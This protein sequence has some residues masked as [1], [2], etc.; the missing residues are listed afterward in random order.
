MDTSPVIE[1]LIKNKYS[2]YDS[3]SLQKF[4]DYL[5]RNQWLSTRDEEIPEW[6]DFIIQQVNDFQDIINILGSTYSL[7]SQS[8]LYCDASL[9]SSYVHELGL[10]T[11]D[12]PDYFGSTEYFI[13]TLIIYAISTFGDAEFAI[14]TILN[15]KVPQEKDKITLILS[16]FKR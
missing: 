5:L 13:K 2:S 16:K 4:I 15:K 12:F 1:S 7:L 9:R 14:K 10:S 3:K 11:I 6:L 8:N